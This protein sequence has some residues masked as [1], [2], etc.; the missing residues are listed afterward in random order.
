MSVE[1]RGQPDGGWLAAA[2]TSL[3]FVVYYVPTTYIHMLPCFFLLFPEALL[4]VVLWR[5]MS[6]LSSEVDFKLRL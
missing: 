5:E 1:T 3:R 6:R 2:G 4:R